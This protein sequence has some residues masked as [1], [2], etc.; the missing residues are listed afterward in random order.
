MPFGSRLNNF[1][2]VVAGT[3]LVF[4]FVLS[5]VGQVMYNAKNIKSLVQQQ[6]VIIEQ[7]RDILDQHHEM[8]LILRSLERRYLAPPK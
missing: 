1:A 8:L 7:N 2:A 5:I 4:S 6:A 3:F